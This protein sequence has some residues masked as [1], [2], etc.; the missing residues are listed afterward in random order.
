MC[1]G[2]LAGEEG[3]RKSKVVF[4]GLEFAAL[5]K[6]VADG[7]K[8]FPSEVDFSMQGSYTCGIGMDVL[9]ALSGVGYICGIKISSYMFAGGV[10]SYLALIPAIAYFGGD[11]ASKVVDD[12]G[13]AIAFNQLA[14]GQIWSNY[15]RYIG[16]G[17]VA[18]GGLISLIKSL[19]TMVKTFSRAVKGFGKKGEAGDRT[20][21]DIPMSAVLGRNRLL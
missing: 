4:S 20:Q 8:L 15:I 3:G 10:L 21:R 19:P 12:A 7:L 14:P 9:P 17:A 5:Y 11:A 6:F 16:A 2:S 13:K 1:R 18:A